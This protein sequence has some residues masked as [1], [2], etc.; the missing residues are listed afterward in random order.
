MSETAVLSGKT[1]APSLTWFEIPCIDIERASAFYFS[2]LGRELVEFEDDVPMRIFPAGEGKTTGALVVRPG[3][4]PTT[5]GTIVFL[6]CE[7]D[8]DQTMARVEPA[9]GVV[10]EPKTPVPG[11][12]GEYFVMRDSEGNKVGV[13]QTMAG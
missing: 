11:G 6:T 2:V 1:S 10:T 8:L 3:V 5:N 4:Q 13:H 7:S 12:R 9:G